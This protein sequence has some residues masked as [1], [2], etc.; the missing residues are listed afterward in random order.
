MNVYVPGFIGKQMLSRC[1]VTAWQFYWSYIGNILNK[2]DLNEN[3]N[4]IWILTWKAW[5][6]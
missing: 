3:L 2:Y 4:L 5:K 1:D 6:W